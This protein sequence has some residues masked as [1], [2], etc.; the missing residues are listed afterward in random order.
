M[1]KYSQTLEQRTGMS[2]KDTW[3]AWS[4][5]PYITTEADLYID[6]MQP[7]EWSSPAM[8]SDAY[9]TYMNS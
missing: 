5:K 7:L 6:I 4:L 8:S 9:I 1:L 2:G 3:N